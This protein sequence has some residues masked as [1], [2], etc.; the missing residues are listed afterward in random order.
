MAAEKTRVVLTVCRDSQIAPGLACRRTIR[1]DWPARRRLRRLYRQTGADD[2]KPCVI[3]ALSSPAELRST[4]GGG[5]PLKAPGHQ[6]LD[7]RCVRPIKPVSGGVMIDP[8]ERHAGGI[9]SESKIDDD[10][11]PADP[12]RS[13]AA[14]FLSRR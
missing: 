3:L 1:G 14:A 13:R 11:R 8:S 10:E 9:M 4:V 6:P 12:A 2:E 7:V 5:D